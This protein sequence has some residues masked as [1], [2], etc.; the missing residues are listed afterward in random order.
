MKKLQFLSVFIFTLLVS[1]F[2][3]AQNVTVTGNA[4]LENQTNHENI[5]VIFERTAPTTLKDTFYT[6]TVGSYTASIPTGVYNVTFKK[7]NYIDATITGQ[8]L[9]ANTAL[10]NTTLESI[11]LSGNLTGVIA[12][13]TY[14]IGGNI[15]VPSGQTLTIEAGTKF[16]FKTDVVFEVEGTLMANGNVNDTIVFTSNDTIQNWKG[17]KFNSAN[18][19][20]KM[21]YCI[22]EKSKASGLK[23]YNCSPSFTNMI[24][25]NNLGIGIM[26]PDYDGGG[27]INLRN[28]NS[29]FDSILVIDNF[30][31]IGG[32]V[33]CIYSNVIIK[34]SAIKHN[35]SFYTAGG[36]YLYEKA[37]MKLLN[38]KIIDNYY[39]D[40]PWGTTPNVAPGLHCFKFVKCEIINSVIANNNGNGIDVTS[41]N[42]PGNI[43]IKNSVIMNN[44]E[45]GI[46]FYETKTYIT[47]SIISNNKEY[48]VYNS[49]S[50]ISGDYE[51]LLNNNIYNNTLGS[52]YKCN[53]WIGKNITVNSNNDS[54]DAYLNIQKDPMFV[55]N[56]D[57]H[58][59]YGSPCIDAGV[60]DSVAFAFDMDN[61]NRIF[62]GDS[63]GVATVDMGVYEFNKP[64]YLSIKNNEKEVLDFDVKL[65]PNPSNNLINIYFENNENTYV[66]VMNVNSQ[67][68]ISKPLENNIVNKISISDLQT[69]IYFIRVYSKN[70]IWN[71]KL[72]KY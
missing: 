40:S 28:S 22:I 20:S 51:H 23:V 32:G 41:Y 53:Q 56:T 59:Q 64:F 33:F 17:I 27:G 18:S 10:N 57:Y 19:N 61:N 38:V 3:T 71:S 16:I 46:E 60:N 48:G 1:N 15:K 58:L 30:C 65:Y 31:I 6:N 35:R 2:V 14:K 44:N 5:S 7:S 11:G 68:I 55:S 70:K 34:N 50:N 37:S 39:T 9:Y 42:S 45:N 63:N 25:R 49:A 8:A 26:T 29:I 13:N 66:E 52:F 4:Y 72:I 36:I 47:N 69:G 21:S 54:C 24:V 62:D 43:S 12:K 67:K